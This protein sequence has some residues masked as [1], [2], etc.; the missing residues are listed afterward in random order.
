MT[1]ASGILLARHDRVLVVTM[2]RQEVR[3]A[4]HPTALHALADVIESSGRDASIGALVLTGAGDRAFCTGMD[5]RALMNGQAEAAGAAIEALERAFQS[6]ER[7]P[8]I[9]AVQA[10]A[11]GGGF[12]LMLKCDL[13]IAAETVMFGLPEVTRGMVPGGGATLLPARI[14]L[15]LALEIALTGE[16][17]SAARLLQLGL[18]NKVV[19]AAEVQTAAIGLAARIAK[20]APL[21][22][23][24]TRDLM[25]TTYQNGAAQGKAALDALIRE[26]HEG[27]QREMREGL[28]AFRE[29]RAPKWRES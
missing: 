29:K 11:I 24:A 5:L 22:V 12:E 28:A 9:S 27:R 26:R 13:A 25:W 6:P 16:L 7:A 10:D 15:A 1:D 18:L 23:A 14:P 20:N 17:Q 4:L 21:A 19:P 8:I 2:D 3:N